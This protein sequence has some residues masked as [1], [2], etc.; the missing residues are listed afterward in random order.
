MRGCRATFSRD[1]VGLLDESNA[2]SRRVRGLRGRNDISCCDP[3]AGA[4]TEH[5]RGLRLVGAVQVRVGR[6]EWS[7]DLERID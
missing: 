4:M 3:A 5:E 2:E 7:V 1:A 6:A